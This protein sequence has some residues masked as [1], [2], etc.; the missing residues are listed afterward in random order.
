VPTDPGV[1][2]VVRPT[3]TLPEFLD[4]SPAGWFKGKDPTVPVAELT[5]LWVPGA[6]VVYIDKASTGARTTAAGTP[7]EPRAAPL[8][9]SWNHGGFVFVR[10]DGGQVADLQ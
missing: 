4:V 5:P 8:E 3:V 10:I 6:R 1:Y 9:P 2:A 7:L